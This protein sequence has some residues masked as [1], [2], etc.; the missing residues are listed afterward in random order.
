[1]LHLQLA[2][3]TLIGAL[4]AP[5]VGSPCAQ[6]RAAVSLSSKVLLLDHIN[7]NH[8]KGR[9]DLLRAFYFD[10]LGCAVDPRKEENLAKGR[11][12]LWA[13]IGIHQFHFSEGSPQAQT[14]DGCVTLAYQ[15]LDALRTRLR[16]PPA[17]LSGSM[18]AWEEVAGG[19]LL[20]T[21]PWGTHIRIAEDAAAADLRGSQPG[22][23]S[24]G[25]AMTQLLLHAPANV[26]L[27]A[28]G[29]FYDHVLGLR[30][31]V[32]LPSLT[33]RQLAEQL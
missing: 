18:F 9:H 11:K 22:F 2:A 28:I 26:D 8:E 14:L 15:Q 24:E 5:T 27:S 19:G 3:V 21:D 33:R 10:L 20:L 31:R 25:L 29:R 1:M 30:Q 12:T 4:R 23:S 32:K 6:P 17:V 7:I 16:T 13:N